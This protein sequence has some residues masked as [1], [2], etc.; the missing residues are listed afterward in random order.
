M[1]TEA[2]LSIIIKVVCGGAPKEPII[3][4]LRGAAAVLFTH[5]QEWKLTELALSITVLH[6]YHYI[7]RER[8]STLYDI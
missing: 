2:I 8:E 6:L 3:S 5:E 4:T 7:R 1:G